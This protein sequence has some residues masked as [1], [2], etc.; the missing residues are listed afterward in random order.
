MT[1]ST[2]RELQERFAE[3]FLADDLDG[4]L[5]LYEDAAVFVAQ[6]GD[7]GSGAVALREALGGFLGIPRT[8]FKL[9]P[10]FAVEADGVALM[11]AD[12]SLE[13][14]DPEGKP[15]SLGGATVEVARRQA[16]GSWRYAVDSPFG[17]VG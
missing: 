2:P 3:Y 8:S 17:I 14:T 1:V 7:S 4:L 10:T 13:G 15:L 12:W 16:D 9:T 11:H 6:S 5:S